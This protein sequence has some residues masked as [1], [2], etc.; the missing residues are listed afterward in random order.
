M[1]QQQ[2]NGYVWNTVL[3]FSL[4][5]FTCTEHDC[6]WA[7][8][9]TWSCAHWHNLF[10]ICKL[11]TSPGIPSC[12]QHQSWHIS[13]HTIRGWSDT[14][15]SATFN[16]GEHFCVYFYIHLHS[17]FFPRPPTHV[18]SSCSYLNAV[19]MSWP[20]VRIC[21]CG[22][23]SLFQTS[24]MKTSLIRMLLLSLEKRGFF[25]S[26]V[27]LLSFSHAHSYRI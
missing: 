2:S 27:G 25:D 12:V 5:Q 4:E 22:G 19:K 6:S 1:Q 7:A 20:I 21:H 8:A 3:V 18:A 10:K 16:L 23:T 13:M 11:Y 15:N 17:L 9:C 24:E 26:V 14:G